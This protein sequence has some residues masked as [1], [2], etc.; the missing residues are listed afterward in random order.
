MHLLLIMGWISATKDM[1]GS[2][3]I[4]GSGSFSEFLSQD[5]INKRKD[6]KTVVV[7]LILLRNTF[8][9]VHKYGYRI[10]SYDSTQ[11]ALFSRSILGIQRHHRPN[12]RLWNADSFVVSSRFISSKVI[13]RPT[14][15][16][17]L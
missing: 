1:L 4:I 6:K 5:N 10:I 17:Q 14:P 12:T 15:I 9:Y 13:Q 3:S 16:S 7:F 11:S 2:H 8:I